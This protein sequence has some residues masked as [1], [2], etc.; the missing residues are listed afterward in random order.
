MWFI[1]KQTA[2]GLCCRGTG[3]SSKLS[4]EI[5]G[6]TN[7]LWKCPLGTV[8]GIFFGMFGGECWVQ[9]S[10][11]N[12]ACSDY[13]SRHPGLHSDTHTDSFW[14]AMLQSQP[15]ERNTGSPNQQPALL[16][17]CFLLARYRRQWHYHMMLHMLS[18]ISTGCWW[19][20]ILPRTTVQSD[21][22]FHSTL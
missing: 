9:T 1:G 8:G 6:V 19:S 13:D 21:C 4:G 3:M 11:G 16:H 20:I 17:F 5:Y 10:G 12:S 22:S 15:A 14:P 18:W 7:C 2:H